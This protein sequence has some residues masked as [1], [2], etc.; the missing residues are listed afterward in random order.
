MGKGYRWCRGPELS[1]Y[2]LE[3]SSQV[4]SQD[5]VSYEVPKKFNDAIQENDSGQKT[6]LKGQQGQEGR[7]LVK[8]RRECTRL[9]AGMCI[10]IS[11]NFQKSCPGSTKE[12]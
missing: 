4:H 9:D 2:T 8:L 10:L 5:L 1:R 3:F 11:Y 12:T 6:K 7:L